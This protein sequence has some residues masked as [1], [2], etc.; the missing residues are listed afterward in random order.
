ML[1][2]IVDLPPEPALPLGRALAEHPAHRRAPTSVPSVTP[3]GRLVMTKRSFDPLALLAGLQLA[4]LL[5]D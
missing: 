2:G 4:G 1:W 3:D 5:T